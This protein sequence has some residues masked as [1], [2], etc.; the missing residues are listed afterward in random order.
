MPSSQYHHLLIISRSGGLVFSQTLSSGA[1]QLSVND[2]MLSGSTFH[3]L[4]AIAAQVAPVHSSGIQRL[5]SDTLALQCFQSLTGVKFILTA[6]AG[7]A[8]LE[9]TLLSV[10]TLYGEYVQKDPWQE[11]DMPIRSELFRKH[12]HS[13]F[14]RLSQSSKSG[15]GRSSARA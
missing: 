12:I 7:T 13:L 15:S 4:H 9:G 3:S 11:P 10:Y 6:D 5:E 1:A 2:L 8:D 14:E